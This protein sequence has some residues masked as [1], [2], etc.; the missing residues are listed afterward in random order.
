MANGL[1]F[2]RLDD[3]K[4]W[5]SKTFAG[6]KE[7]SGLRP[8]KS[9]I[10]RLTQTGTAAPTATVLENNLTGT[11]AYARTGAGVYTITLTGQFTANKTSV[12]VSQP[13]IGRVAAVATSANVVT[14][15]TFDATLTAAA[16]AILTGVVV[17]IRVYP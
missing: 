9:L 13:A 7:Q 2:N 14:V 15:S 4:A 1:T 10:L 12:F 16:D 8:Y 6:S 5:L 17:E 11:I 3:V